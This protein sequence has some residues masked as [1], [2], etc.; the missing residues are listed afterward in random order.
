MDDG[1][2]DRAITAFGAG[3][4]RR[5]GLRATLAAFVAAIAV[6]GGARA[7]GAPHHGNGGHDGS[8]ASANG[9]RHGGG[10][11]GK[12]GKG[13]NTPAAAKPDSKPAGDSGAT[14]PTAAAAPAGESGADEQSK[15]TTGPCGDGSKKA[16]KCTVDADCCTSYCIK[17]TCSCKTA[18]GS[19]R[20]NA[21]CCAGTFCSNAIC[22]RSGATPA[23]GPQGPEGP[24]G[25]QGPVGPGSTAAGPTGPSGQG[26]TGATGPTGASSTIAGPQG[27]TG[28]AGVVG[29]G[30]PQGSQGAQGP[31]GTQGAVGPQ[32]SQGAVGPQ[33]TQGTQG[34]QGVTGP[35]GPQGSQGFT[36]ATGPQGAQGSQGFTG[37]QGAQGSQ[38]FT[39]FTG[40]QG[41][42]GAQGVTGPQ[43][44]QG[45]TGPTGPQGAQGFTG[46][47]GATGTTGSTGPTGPQGAQGSQGF[48]GAASTVTGPTGPVATVVSDATFRISDNAD[49]T[50]L[51]AFEVGGV[52]GGTTVTLT[53]PTASATLVGLDTSQTL[54]NKILQGGGSTAPIIR[55]A[56][57][58]TAPLLLFQNSG[59]TELLR[60]DTRA[61]ENLFVGNAAGAVNT[62]T[63]NTGV[64]D[65]ALGSNTSGSQN[66]AYGRQ[67]L[68][69]NT[70]GS[71][72]TAVGYQ[73]LQNNTSGS[74]NTAVGYQALQT[75][76]TIYAT[77]VGA[78]ISISGNN[79]SALGSSASVT[80]DNGT[81]IGSNA[82]AGTNEVQ[83][84][85]SATTVY[86]YNL[87]QRSDMRDKTD[88][89]D[90]TLGLDFI[91][92]LRPVDYR[93]DY[94]DAYR[95]ARPQTDDPAALAAWQEASKLAN[96]RN[97]GS[98]KR[99]RFHHG[100]IAQEVQ[101]VLADRGIDFGGF[102]DHTINGGDDVLTL[103]Y[104]ELIAPL[105]KAVQELLG[106]VE[107]L[108]ANERGQGGELDAIRAAQADLLARFETLERRGGFA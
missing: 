53:P 45:F 108:Q 62:G 29:Q 106:A 60:I 91:A 15:R 32:G 36:G 55:A 12:S 4:S 47:T 107:A 16:N 100:L 95:P 79:A 19:C 38:G 28:P 33:G 49:A 82:V 5:S 44:P 104:M 67:A 52:T 23:A 86:Y 75:G 74:S 46:M 58:Q 22:V 18:G 25:P 20:S 78:E 85:D 13:A 72:N 103:G 39:G 80:G 43:G 21:A 59:G 48:T 56:A 17:G 69:L 64:G 84:G 42:Q 92:A 7:T 34:A 24:Q 94:R 11:S 8:G 3:I 77:A 61:K 30:G 102:Q 93:W 97:D 40:A 71:S 2:F 101:Q 51:L 57:A 87:S 66:A 99:E 26:P 35:Q 10:K 14:G 50:R 31:Q 81:A 9:D 96:L 83:L 37:P 70:L 76:G 105:I 89:R 63:S 90:T 54:T 1:T 41:A 98:R 88:I 6:S 73:A 27:F 65:R 68:H